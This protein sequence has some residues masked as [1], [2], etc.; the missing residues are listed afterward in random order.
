MP[1][2]EVPLINAINSV[3][4][5]IL[6][7][8]E[9]RIRSISTSDLS[10]TGESTTSNH[11]LGGYSDDEFVFNFE[12]E[13]FQLEKSQVGEEGTTMVDNIESGMDQVMKESDNVMA[14]SSEVEKIINLMKSQLEDSND[15]TSI[16]S[17]S[18]SQTSYK[19]LSSSVNSQGNFEKA[20]NDQLNSLSDGLDLLMQCGSDLLSFLTPTEGKELSGVIENTMRT[21]KASMQGPSAGLEKEAPKITMTTPQETELSHSVDGEVD[22]DYS[23]QVPNSEMDQNKDTIQ[24]KADTPQNKDTI[25]RKGDALQNKDKIQQR[26][27]PLQN[28]DTIQRK[29]DA[30]QNKDTI[31]RK[32]DAPQNKDTIQ[33]KADALQNKD[34]IQRKADP[35]QNEDTIQR[36]ADPLQNEDTIQQK[37]DALQNKDKIQQRADTLQNEDT[38][39]I[40][41]RADTQQNIDTIQ[42]RADALQN[43]DTIQRK[44]DAL[45]NKDKIQQK[46]DTLQNKDTIQQRADTLQNEDTITIQQKAD[47]LQNKD[48]IQRKADALQN[49]DTITIQQKADVLQNKD[50]IQRKADVLQ[51]NKTTKAE[52]AFW[53]R[54]L[55]FS[56]LNHKSLPSFSTP[57]RKE[58]E[59]NEEKQEEDD[60]VII[61]NEDPQ[62]KKGEADLEV[63]VIPDSPNLE[64]NIIISSEGN[65]EPEEAVK[66]VLIIS[67]SPSSFEIEFSSSE[68]KDNETIVD[69]RKLETGCSTRRISPIRFPVLS[70]IT[71]MKKKCAFE[72]DDSEE[73]IP[74][75]NNNIEEIPDD[76]NNNIEA[77][78]TE[79]GRNK[80]EKPHVKLHATAQEK[81][82]HIANKMVRQEN[83]LKTESIVSRKD[84]AKEKIVP[85]K[86]SVS[87][88]ESSH[89]EKTLTVII[90]ETK[91]KLLS[92]RQSP[93]LT[94]QAE[95]KRGESSPRH[96]PRIQN[97]EGKDKVMSL[98]ER[99]SSQPPTAES[100]P[101]RRDVFSRLSPQINEDVKLPESVSPVKEVRTIQIGPSKLSK[102]IPSQTV[103]V[104][105][106][107]ENKNKQSKEDSLVVI[108]V[109]NERSEVRKKSRSKSPVANRRLFNYK[110]PPTSANAEPLSQVCE[111]FEVI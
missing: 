99:T 90:P 41:Q 54:I 93:T 2:S 37:A 56:N 3:I 108:T 43:K 89:K 8:K 107:G 104:E 9:G 1:P 78:N 106:P 4:H 64:E 49:K 101:K 61:L 67:E 5:K 95:A 30:P 66:D 98:G 18:S 14:T 84:K 103:D 81:S 60:S 88:R 53:S 20:L 76:N 55:G 50:T 36:K 16:S 97:G 23:V 52:T 111:T 110:P 25:Q 38:I 47:A 105:K 32:A 63:V 57:P 28:E 34:T 12:E 27:D 73:E 22:V 69:E 74:D 48:I 80:E 17:F 29:A 100:Q 33:R 42:Q 68:E 77:S 7:E 91:R 35:L 58:E 79:K 19:S 44:A 71:V 39:T 26:A 72:T 85:N 24:R 21:L 86:E 92:Q 6:P 51:D 82:A 40:Q 11:K 15:A 13:S 102:D 70:N 31:Q 109:S 83:G 96:S 62:L 10:D 65:S 94:V 45:Q 87:G 46:A 75:D 59:I